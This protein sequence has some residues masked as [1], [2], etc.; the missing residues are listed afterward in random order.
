M[1]DPY[2]LSRFVTAQAGVYE[3]A[4]SELRAGR[5][6]SHWM[7]FVFPQVKG[8]GASPTSQEYA[9][10]SLAEAEAYLAHPILGPRLRECTGLVLSIPNRPAE[11]IFGDIDAM[12]LRSSMTL[13]HRAAPNEPDFEEVL[14]KYFDGA[15]DPETLKRL[16]LV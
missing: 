8:L 16:P 13:F 12:K 1:D 3:A 10:T 9:I 2:R 6:S 7:W 15:E 11:L 14:T 4:V 5:K